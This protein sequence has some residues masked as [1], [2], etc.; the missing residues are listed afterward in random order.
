MSLE[1]R[2]AL[3]CFISLCFLEGPSRKTQSAYPEGNPGELW[4]SVHCYDLGVE[5]FA[6][7][8]N[9]LWLDSGFR[10]QVTED[11]HQRFLMEGAAYLR[12]YESYYVGKDI[13]QLPWKAER[14]AALDVQF[15]YTRVGLD[16][17]ELHEERQSCLHGETGEARSY[18]MVEQA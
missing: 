7:A 16:I 14:R 4:Q 8:M 3:Y 15:F 17:E 1:A 9:R 12:H 5:H 13:I 18:S 2:A 11:Y 10:R 6:Q